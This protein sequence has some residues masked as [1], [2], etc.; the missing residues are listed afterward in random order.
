MARCEAIKKNGEQ[1]KGSAMEGSLFCRSHASLSAELV[2][3]TP[4][5]AVEEITQVEETAPVEEA[6][7][8]KERVE[9]KGQKM[10]DRKPASRVRL[11]NRESDMI[12]V[13]NKGKMRRI[14]YI[15]KGRYIIASLGL[16]LGPE[17]YGR[18]IDVDHAF[19]ERMHT[20]SDAMSSFEEV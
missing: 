9:R 2:E 18:E 14:R 1:C 8:D 5:V 10:E 11:G 12:A 16:N 20:N 6:Q 3:E 19:W 17:D 13:I 15:G 4:P 7:T